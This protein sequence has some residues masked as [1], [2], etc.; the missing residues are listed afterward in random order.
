MIN[1]IIHE[2][3][4]HMQK[5]VE[6]VQHEMALIRTGRATTNLLDVVRV[7]YYGAHVPVNQVA[8]IGVP[9][10][11]LLTIQPWDKSAISAIEKAILASGL[12]LTP[13]NDGTIIRL[14]IPQ[15][16]EERRK[17]LVRVVHKL[18]EEGRVS[19]RN[20]RREANEMLKEGEKEGEIPEDDCKKAQKHVQDLTD[21][22]IKKIDEILKRKEAEIMEV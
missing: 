6:S 7:E 13:S 20:A 2:T 9:E 10:P 22:H 18:A 15:L 16:T 21:E 3:K 8:T 12:G 1:D 11:R 17:D 4:S 5:A 14:P 19:I